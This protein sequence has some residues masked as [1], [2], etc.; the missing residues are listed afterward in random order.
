METLGNGTFGKVQ[1]VMYTEEEKVIKF[2]KFSEWVLTVKIF[3][4]FFPQ[5]LLKFK[6]LLIIL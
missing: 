4:V 6:Q 1:K 5:I 3:L 2:L